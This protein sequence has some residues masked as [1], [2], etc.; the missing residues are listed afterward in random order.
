MNFLQKLLVLSVLL[1]AGLELSA[2]GPNKKRIFV[3][4][5]FGADLNVQ[6]KTMWTSGQQTI[7]NGHSACIAQHEFQ[8][9]VVA[10]N[11]IVL[12]GFYQVTESVEGGE[13]IVVTKKSKHVAKLKKYKNKKAFLAANPGYVFDEK[14]LCPSVL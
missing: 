6:Y 1:V 10:E 4:N 9:I 13:I 11:S 7:K 12:K 5:N 8:Q 2:K 3:I 14:D